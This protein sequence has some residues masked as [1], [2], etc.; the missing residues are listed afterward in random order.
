MIRVTSGS[1]ESCLIN[2]QRQKTGLS[3]IEVWGDSLGSYTAPPSPD[4][5]L[6]LN[7][8]GD[9][10]PRADASFHDIYGGLPKWANDGRVN[11]RPTPVNRWTSYGS[12][13][14]SDW[15]EI[16]FGAPKEVS[17][18][19]LYIYDDHGGVQ[20]PEG[21]T[22]QVLAN[23]QWR[24]AGHQIKNPAVPIGSA[25]NTVT[26]SRVTTQKIRVV[27]THRGESRS[28]VTEMEVWKE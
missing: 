6:A 18:V 5:N 9:G 20:P 1:F 16:D 14:V 8:K 3:E 19:E 27:F 4:G 24:D 11:Y 15:L 22:V 17:R 25:I 26:F 7:V 21:Y 2:K 23:G 28:G 13:N 10:F 12:K